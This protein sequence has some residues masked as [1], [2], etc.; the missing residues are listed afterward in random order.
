MAWDTAQ[1]SRAGSPN[2]RG[3]LIQLCDGGRGWG[4]NLT[5]FPRGCRLARRVREG[6]TLGTGSRKGHSPAERR[7]WGDR[8]QQL[9]DASAEQS[10]RGGCCKGQQDWRECE[11]GHTAASAPIP[12]RP[13]RLIPAPA[14]APSGCLTVLPF[15]P[16]PF[17][18]SLVFAAETGGG[19]L[20]I[21]SHSIVGGTSANRNCVRCLG[22]RE[23]G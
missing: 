11:M 19:G 15:V 8:G 20:R 12:W 22:N 2:L 14:P 3:K 16:T 7:G 17:G 1:A 5:N 6:D 18:F 13:R 21:R 4:C 10:K 23:E 9:N